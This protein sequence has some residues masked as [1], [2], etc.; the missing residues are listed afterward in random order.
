MWSWCDLGA[1]EVL[2]WWWSMVVWKVLGI[3]DLSNVIQVHVLA[4]YL[5]DVRAWMHLVRPTRSG[6]VY[7]RCFFDH[8][9]L[10][11]GKI[12]FILHN[13][14]FTL[15][16]YFAQIC[17][18]IYSMHSRSSPGQYECRKMNWH[19]YVVWGNPRTWKQKKPKSRKPSQKLSLPSQIHIDGF[20]QQLVVFEQILCLVTFFLSWSFHV[21]KPRGNDLLFSR[22]HLLY[23]YFIRVLLCS[24]I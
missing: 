17:H 24:K 12:I 23:C 6:D 18:G 15:S 10:H 21:C 19:V 7:K 14:S 3:V 16:N 20:S 4:N 13:F 2:F 8:L 9:F 11:I 5:T 22:I 1:S